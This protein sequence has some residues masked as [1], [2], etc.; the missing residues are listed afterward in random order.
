MLFRSYALF[1]STV[2][3]GTSSTPWKSFYSNDGYFVANQRVVSVQQ[4]TGVAEAAF[5][6]NS[7]GTA[8][9]VDSTFGGYTIQ[10]ITQ[11]LQNH[12]LLA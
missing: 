7:G 9:N 6:E 10:Q 4:T 3:F 12:G 8:V 11:A 1:G 5:V 2:T